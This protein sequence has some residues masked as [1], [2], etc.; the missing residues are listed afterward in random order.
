MQF[1]SILVLCSLDTRAAD[2]E[3][4]LATMCSDFFFFARLF[5]CAFSLLRHL[6]QALLR[7]HNLDATDPSVFLRTSA[8]LLGAMVVSSSATSSQAIAPEQLK[9]LSTASANAAVCRANVAEAVSE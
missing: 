2:M 7:A 5:S 1:S 9:Q 6:P 3:R 4:L 8:F